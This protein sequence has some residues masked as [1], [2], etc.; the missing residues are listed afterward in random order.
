MCHCGMFEYLCS[1]SLACLSICVVC[2]CG[3]L[4]IFVVCHC[5]VLS[6][7]AACQWYICVF[8]CIVSQWYVFEYL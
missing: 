2:H 1:V 6:I 7:C 4:S 5:G 3:V 8:E